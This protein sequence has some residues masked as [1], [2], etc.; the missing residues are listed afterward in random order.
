LFKT[1]ISLSLF[2][3]FVSSYASLKTNQLK[4][5]SPFVYVDEFGVKLITDVVDTNSNQA[6]DLMLV[7]VA[8]DGWMELLGFADA[9]S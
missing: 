4:S 7:S 5:S 8:E 1:G 6:N 3:N 9:N 2:Q